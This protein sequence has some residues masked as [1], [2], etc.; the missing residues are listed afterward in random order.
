MWKILQKVKYNYDHLIAIA[1]VVCE[2][3][4]PFTI[5]SKENEKKKQNYLN[6]EFW[7]MENNIAF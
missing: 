6:I 5:E 4:T 2:K 1:S 3:T 7:T